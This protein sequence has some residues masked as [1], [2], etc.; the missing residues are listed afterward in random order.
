MFKMLTGLAT[1]ARTFV[2]A[3]AMV[4]WL[5]ATL[6]IAV[7]R[8]SILAAAGTFLAG[9]LLVWAMWN[10]DWIRDKGGEDVRN[11]GLGVVEHVAR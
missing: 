4:V 5:G 3:V 11:H 2:L 7:T 9:A 1:D 8:R 6:A 10:A